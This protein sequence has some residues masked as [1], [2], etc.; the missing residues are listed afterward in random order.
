MWTKPIEMCVASQL[1]C[2]MCKADQYMSQAKI[3][4]TK[5]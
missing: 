2:T 1:M 4:K 3:T 5:D